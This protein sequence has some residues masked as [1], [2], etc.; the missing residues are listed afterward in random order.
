MWYDNTGLANFD[1]KIQILLNYNIPGN[2]F[3]DETHEKVNI[4]T[5]FVKREFIS[6]S[7]FRAN[8]A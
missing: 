8:T 6:Y 1:I 5:D 3:I 4:Q 7:L 2:R